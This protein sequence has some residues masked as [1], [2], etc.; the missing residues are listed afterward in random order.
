MTSRNF[1]TLLIMFLFAIGFVLFVS[2]SVFAR[3]VGQWANTDP[4]INA[5]YQGLMQPDYPALSCCGH[6]DAYW[7]DEIHIRDSK[8]YCN[9]TDD[10]VRTSISAPKCLSPITN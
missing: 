5:W 8:T 9:I 4:T 3:D 1:T 2:P 6:S 10:R 7:C